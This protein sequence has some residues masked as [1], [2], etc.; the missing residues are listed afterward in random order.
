MSIANKIENKKKTKHGSYNQ[1]NAYQ[2]GFKKSKGKIIFFLDF[3]Q[4]N[5]IIHIGE[6]SAK[7]SFWK[8]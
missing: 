1:I 2:L 4:K 3:N 5:Y 6:I 7:C 8:K